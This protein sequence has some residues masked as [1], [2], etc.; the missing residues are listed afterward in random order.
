MATRHRSSGLWAGVAFGGLAFWLIRRHSRQGRQAMES[1][2][3]T[4]DSWLPDD[5]LDLPPDSNVLGNDDVMA[6]IFDRPRR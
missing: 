1:A 2:R 3:D 6:E 5:V 4:S